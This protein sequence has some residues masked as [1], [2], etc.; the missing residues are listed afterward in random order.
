MKKILLIFAFI[1]AYLTNAQVSSYS[2]AQ[3][4]GAYTALPTTS[5][6]V[7]ATAT[8]SNSLDNAVYPVTLPFNVSFNG[9][10][11]AALNVSTNGFITFGTTAPGT[12]TYSP[13]S[14]TETYTGAV[15][16][17]GRDLNA[18]A[19]VTN[20]F[21]NVS[22]GVE[23]TAPNRE[24]VIQW[25]DFRPVYTT[26]TTNAYT[27]SFQI[28][29]RETTNT[30]AVVYKAGSYLAGTTA[31]SS[32]V[33][34]GLRG[35]TNAD[36][37]NRTNSTSVLFTASTA[38]A[39]NTSSQAF[40]TTAA[41]P[42]MFTD[43][44]TYIWTPPSCFAPS[45]LV[46]S[47]TSP[48]TGSIGWA[49]PSTVPANGYEYI[50]STTNTAPPAATAGTPTTALTVPINALTTGT[51]Y[52]W[53]V[54]S[55][56]SG[57]DKSTWIA[58]PPFTP[59]QIGSGTLSNGNLPIYSCY[60][61]NYS[62]QIYTAAEVGG[63]IGTNN[64]ITKIR[65]YVESTA[66]TQANYN[67][68]VV[69][70]GNTT[71]ASFASTTNWVPL[72]GMQ[73]VYTGTLPNM[74]GGS[75]VELTLTTP[76]VWN[77]T[78]NI[79]IAVDE[80]ASG[81]SCTQNWGNYAA[82]ANRGILHYDDTVNADPSS[83]PTA[84][85]RYSDIPRIQ[86]IAQQLLACTTAPP[87]NITVGQLTPT[88]AGVSWTPA[89]GATYI[90]RWRTAPS[91]AW[92]QITLTAPLTSSYTIPGL[93]ELTAYEVQ[94]ATICGG[95]TGAFSPST[96]FTT[97]AITYCTSGPTSTTVYEYI[98]NVTVTP[99]GYAPMVSNSATPPPFYS[100]YT[101]D[102]TRL[103]TLIRGTSNNSISAT[104][105]W[106]NF[107]YAS[108]TRAWIDFNRN[109]IFGDNPNELVLDS[110]SNTTSIVN[111]PNFSVPT[112]AQGAYAGNLNVRMRVII[113]EGGV[114]SPCGGFTWGEVEDYSVR[115]IDLLPC[116]TAA[117]SNITVANMTATTAYVSW[118]PAAGATYQVRWRQIGQTLWQ[119]Q[120]AG[121]VTIPAGQS[122][123]TITGLTEQTNYE[124]QVKTICNG[125]AGAF[126][127]SV[128][129]T[130]P[131]L[132]Y[133]PM[134]G[135]G[136][137]DYISNVKITPVNF[138]VMDNT[139]LQT[140]YISYT[141]PATLINLEVGSTGNQLSVSKAWQTTTYADAVDA[142][143]DY[144]RDGIFAANEKIMTSASSTTTPVTVTFNV[145]QAGPAIYA[146][147]LTTTLRVI[148]KRSS[149]SVM[150]VDP[151]NGEVEDYAVKL[152]PCSNVTP[153]NVT[154]TPI[155]QNSAT[156][157]WTSVPTNI[158]FVL[159]YRAVTNPVSPWITV[160]AS[161]LT[162][163]PPVQLTGLTP[164]T[165]YEVRIAAK[166]ATGGLGA[167]TPVKL[168]TTRCDPT[169]PNV[170]VTNI[171]ST[172]AVVTWNPIVPSA[173]YLIRYRPVGSTTWISVVAPAPPAN[174]VTLTGLSSYVTY[175]VQVANQCVGET[176]PNPWSNPQVFTT[177]RI[178][179]IPPPGLTITTL[180]PTS[181]E[182][183]WDAFTGAG[184]TGS[185]VLRYRKVGIPSWTTI[186][187]NTNTYTITGL[188]ELTKY[189]MQVANI[190][191]G[192]P[193][194]FTP[195]YY[196][197][198]PTI[199]YCQMSSNNSATEYISKVTVTPTGKPEMINITTASNY[200]DYTT[201]QNKYIEMVQGSNGNSI[202]IDKT[203]TNSASAGVAVWIDFNRNGYFDINERILVDGPNT[204]PTASGTFSV[205]ADAFVS[206][207]DYKYVRMR[208]AM[209]KDGIPVNCANFDNGEVED[210][211]VRISKQGV[212]N[213]VNQTDI[214]IYPNPVTTV[215]N[216]KNISKK[217]NYKIYSAAGQLVS[218]GLILNNKIDVS[219]LINGLYVI[220]IEDVKGTVQKKFIKE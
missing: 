194:N 62:Q 78:S 179:E 76:F 14:S 42:G 77:G 90:V 143:I 16:A 87:T 34:V 33:Q 91:G 142:Y 206:M 6:T 27:F 75:W 167:Y 135:T 106:P 60:G 5:A 155:T 103:V 133:C 58:G 85:S 25:T 157:N 98:S 117:P 121:F 40:S 70:M 30:I 128:N 94:V 136:T 166:C 210:Y 165:T 10:N 88:S 124:V 203:L 173:T 66:T 20:V 89:T 159:E 12:A 95:T 57:T 148:L 138:P 216:V 50:V 144:N 139:S 156:V 37:N 115:L 71:Q 158:A 39:V 131:P 134:V 129:F 180:T 191:S 151:V 220:D 86:L 92:N 161:T 189:E 100:D 113:L 178:C 46:S 59:G 18:I 152:R 109:G 214:L 54:R 132:T 186:N 127:P 153:T 74:T 213:T 192:T 24:V 118:L 2:F 108:G 56:C 96:T 149:G 188:L 17:W 119:Q 69:Y 182:V 172:S 97:P 162:G 101:N 211:T 177:I 137:N 107:Q 183:V 28:R 67:Q 120:P 19:N 170:T 102:P 204:N 181:A 1:T 84:N 150:C 104:K 93:L 81:Y 197:T 146:G 7:L 111:N 51:T 105:V 52:Y 53:W 99:T 141:T 36:Y 21:G 79:V 68:W 9:V 174:S 193:G 122:F 202:T 160:N 47:A 175:E 32:T 38:G 55:I 43:G 8:A 205:P 218:S 41:T 169:P 112:V 168:F 126:G 199:V 116:T 29:L 195:P 217:A 207:T 125:T 13:I 171:T 184:A 130:T 215:L 200:S 3:S 114:P 198:T 11:Y 45:G 80:N 35:T 83:P 63:A 15:S 61:Y 196:F 65:F 201:V 190:C 44:L 147:P 154:V 163:N 31:I 123:Y 219:R 26:S 140:N 176:T 209:Q 212:A 187:V 4:I 208:V 23:G 64:F 145:P 164:A 48:V 82:G 73:Q 185:Y 22:W 110:P 49:A 72:S